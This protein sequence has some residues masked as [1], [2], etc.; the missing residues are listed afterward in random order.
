[1]IQFKLNELYTAVSPCNNDARWIFKVT[2]RTAKTIT[3]K[4]DFPD[5]RKEKSCRLYVRKVY[6]LA[7]TKEIEYI[8][9]LGSYS[10]APSLY[11][12]KKY[13]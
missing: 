12:D 3:I 9:P 1:M 4:G 7:E 10:M 5:G 11:A 8:N 2:K 6:S 13:L